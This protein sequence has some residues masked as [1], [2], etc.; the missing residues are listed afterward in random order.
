[1]P[2]AARKSTFATVKRVRCGGLVPQPGCGR[3][4]MRSP[5]CR[6]RASSLVMRISLCAVLRV[7][8][9]LWRVNFLCL[10]VQ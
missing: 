10:Q 2:D 8:H 4:R 6:A 1:M 3:S 9:F 5:G 7:R